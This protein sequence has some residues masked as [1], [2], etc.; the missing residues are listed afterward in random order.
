MSSDQI[1]AL[2]TPLALHMVHHIHTARNSAVSSLYLSRI[3]LVIS[4]FPLFP[5]SWA[6]SAEKIHKMVG[7][8]KGRP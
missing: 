7:Q 6:G 1:G 4:L 3:S 2:A 5:G 8:M